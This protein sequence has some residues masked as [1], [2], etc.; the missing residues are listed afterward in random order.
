MTKHALS[1]LAIDHD[2]DVLQEVELVLG[3]QFRCEAVED[4]STAR[5]RL[6]SDT[7]DA[8]L[9]DMEMP[10]E[11]GLALVEPSSLSPGQRTRRS[12]SGRR[13]SASTAIW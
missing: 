1:V 10:G 6:A 7:F 3:E 5:E 11:A 8:V 4:V 12:S 9:C 2:P 13:N